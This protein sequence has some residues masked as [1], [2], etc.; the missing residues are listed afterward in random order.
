VHKHDAIVSA[1]QHA[2]HA[3]SVPLP[4]PSLL[5]SLGADSHAAAFCLGHHFNPLAGSCGRCYEVACRATTVRDGYG[6]TLDRTHTCQGQKSVIVTV[7]DTCPCYYPSN[8][9]SNKRW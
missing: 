2:V 1:N 9:Y 6:G 4:P 3:V 8:A 7:T 5:L